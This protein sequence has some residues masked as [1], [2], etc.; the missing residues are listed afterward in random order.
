MPT[1]ASPRL[2]VIVG[3]TAS[4]KTQLSLQLARKV[5]GEIVSCD[6]Q[7]VYRGMDIGT[8]KA[9]VAERSEVPHHVLDVARPDEEMTAARFV[10]LADAA[11]ADIAARGKPVILCGGTGLYVRAL[12]LGL[13]EGPGANPERR[14][15]LTARAA[16]EGVV[17]LHRWLAEV[18]PAIAVKIDRNDEKRIV[19]ALEVYLETGTPMSVHQARHDHRIAP[20]RYPARK[21]GLAPEREL[22]YQRI[23]R[24]VDQM[25]ERGLVAEVAAL[26]AAGYRPPLRSQ[27]AIGYAEIHS[28]LDGE[29]E[30]AQAI[31][32]IKRNSRRY[33]R[34]QLSW[35]RSDQDVRWSPEPD[36][37]DQ[38]EL[39]RYLKGSHA[40]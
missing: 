40:P 31:E 20:P 15:E 16:R 11:I 21:V 35:Y 23:E 12:L 26:R 25:V 5:G 29:L 22:L 6:S 38:D 36:A 37:V 3:P 30:H 17:A 8:G 14:A 13:F 18:D 24:R 28:L 19:R 27:E 9:T 2:V 39:E 34:R 4:G 32:Y 10:G 1:P 7:Q 33:A